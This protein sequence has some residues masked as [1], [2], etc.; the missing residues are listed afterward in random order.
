MDTGDMGKQMMDFYKTTFDNTFNAMEMMQ[1]QT[2]QMIKSFAD[3]APQF[4]GEGKKF[5]DQWLESCKKGRKDFRKMMED[6]FSKG[7]DFFA[8]PGK[9]SREA[10]EKVQKG[11]KKKPKSKARA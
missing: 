11:Q 3:T 9:E 4:P 1:D 8:K 7:E 10:G 5:M 2:E 6:N